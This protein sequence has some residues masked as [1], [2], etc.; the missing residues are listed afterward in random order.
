M[1]RRLLSLCY[2]LI[3]ITSMMSV[4]VIDSHA[5]EEEAIIDGSY[6][7]EDNESIGYDIKLTRGEDLLNG[8]SKCVVMGPGKLYAGGCTVAA[9]KVKEV[10]L[11]VIIERA[12]EGDEHWFRYDGWQKFNENVDRAAESRMLEVEGGYYYR[13]RC[14]HSANS[15]LSSSFTD[16][17][18]VPSP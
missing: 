16:G 6:L 2:A 8:Y 17:V 1:K 4:S 7:T 10:G 18:F 15:D 11:S 9:H 5:A 13:V 12:Q 3:L 14:V